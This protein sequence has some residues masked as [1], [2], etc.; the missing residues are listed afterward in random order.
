MLE[1]LKSNNL[2]L[3]IALT[4]LTF[5][6]MPTPSL[7]AKTLKIGHVLAPKSNQ[8]Q[9]LVTVFKPYVEKA[10]GGSLKINVFPAE[11]L[12][13]GPDQVEGVKLGTQA[14]FLGSQ[15]WFAAH[16]KQIGV[17]TIPFLFDDRSHFQKWMNEVLGK[18]LMPELIQKANQRIINLQPPWERGPFRVIC[19]KKPIFSPEDIKGL[20]LRLWPAQMIQKSWAGLGAKIHTIDFA[21]AYLALKQGVV[22]A[23]T[24]PFDLVDPQKFAE[25]APYIT[26]LRQYP[27]LEL[28]SI[29]EKTWQGLSDKERKA[30]LDGVVETG[31]WYN[32]QAKTRVEETIQLLLKKNDAKYL[33]VNRQ[34]F[35]DSFRNQVVPNL[36]K[37]GLAKEEWI[38]EVESLR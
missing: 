33:L 31:K 9:A 13:H 23:I 18:K 17:A 8:N 32:Q 5:F 10:T 24:S 26:E 27:Q 4:A 21:E 38:K 3:T 30:L 16:I 28:I 29:N 34:P 15:T 35:V 25:V 6:F 19:A 36:I 14:M 22:E 12:G 7:F 11:Q 1:K 20:K 37:G 2:F